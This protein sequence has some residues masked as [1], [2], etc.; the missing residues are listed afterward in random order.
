MAR[1]GSYNCWR[2]ATYWQDRLFSVLAR[3]L[4][5]Y[6]PSL[7][8][9]LGYPLWR[10]IIWCAPVFSIIKSRFKRASFLEFSHLGRL[11]L[12]LDLLD[13]T[14]LRKVWAGGGK[15]PG[16]PPAFRLGPGSLI[17]LHVRWPCTKLYL[18]LLC[19]LSL[20]TNG[21]W[22]LNCEWHLSLMHEV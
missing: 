1:R 12:A 19:I 11:V 10:N 20:A 15:Y 3:S 9:L 21:H 16:T 7:F 5:R 6:T 22:S 13:S 18:W 14:P 4:C 2:K 8:N 17:S